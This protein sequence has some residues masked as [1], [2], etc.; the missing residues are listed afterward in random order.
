MSDKKQLRFRQTVLVLIAFFSVRIA[1]DFTD[2]FGATIATVHAPVLSREDYGTFSA[3]TYNIAGL[4]QF[5][6]SAITPRAESI[7]EIGKKLNIYDVVH[8]QED[9][10]YNDALYGTAN[11][12]PF[13][14]TSLGNVPFGDGLNTLSRFPLRDLE[15]IQWEDCTGADCLTPKGFSFSRI[16]VAEKLFIDFYNVH[17]NA[18]NDLPAAAARRLNMMQLSSFIQGKSG[19]NAVV[20]MGD[21]NGH[22]GYHYDNIRLLLNTLGLKDAWVELRC[23]G[24]V[25]PSSRKLPEGNILALTDTSES[26]DKIL[27]RGSNELQLVVEQYDFEKTLFTSSNGT[28]LSDHHPVSVNFSWT[29]LRKSNKRVL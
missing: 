1:S 23:Q 8:V 3:I 22:Y 21:L 7:S 16:E 10:S 4:P 26:I 27:F 5:I 25:P 11:Q 12:H 19:S 14:T 28:P 29:R 24:K 2:G 9:F 18:Y 6:S 13:R 20:I 15:R 17:M